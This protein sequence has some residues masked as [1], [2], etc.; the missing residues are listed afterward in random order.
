MRRIEGEGGRTGEERNRKWKG[1]KC[2]G[3]GKG[4]RRGRRGERETMKEI[5]KKERKVAY[6]SRK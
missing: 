6:A 2:M 5:K 1:T 4:R 3:Q